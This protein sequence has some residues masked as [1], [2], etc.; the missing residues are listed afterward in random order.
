MT[1][2]DP[3]APAP[4]GL[5]PAW[6]GA[7]AAPVTTRAQPPSIR[8]R[9]SLKRYRIGSACGMGAISRSAPSINP[10]IAARWAGGSCSEDRPFMRLAIPVAAFMGV[11]NRASIAEWL[12]A[13]LMKGRSSEQLPPAQRA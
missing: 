2:G 12:V 4:G 8:L 9:L 6:G 3:G 13:N 7:P 11:A 10:K 5:L 1:Y